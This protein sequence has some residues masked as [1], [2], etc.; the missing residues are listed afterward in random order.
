MVRHSTDFTHLLVYHF[1]PFIL[2]AIA[3]AVFLWAFKRAL[4]S[5]KRGKRKLPKA[6]GLNRHQRREARAMNKQ[7]RR[8]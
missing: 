3:F 7:K 2:L 4:R 6:E 5:K 1:G 8:N